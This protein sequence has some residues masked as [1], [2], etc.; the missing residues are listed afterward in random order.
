M[1]W[2]VNKP[3]QIGPYAFAA[4]TEANAQAHSFG[5]TIVASGEK[6]PVMLLV[7]EG[8]K[9]RSIDLKG[10]EHDAKET[11]KRFPNAIAKMRSML[12]EQGQ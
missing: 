3:I 8:A 2:S 9:V 11:E 10:Q 12:R 6:R 5:P 4:I 7:A 1:S